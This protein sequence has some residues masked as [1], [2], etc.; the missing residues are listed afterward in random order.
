MDKDIMTILH[1]LFALALYV[2]SV[3]NLVASVPN[4]DTYKLA[5]AILFYI[6][7]NKH[8]KSVLEES[9]GEK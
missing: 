9:E 1:L 3:I 4:R 5:M 7:A 2:A 6:M 8:E